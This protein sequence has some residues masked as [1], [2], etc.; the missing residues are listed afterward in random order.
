M[1]HGKSMKCEILQT[2]RWNILNERNWELST[3]KTSK[4]IHTRVFWRWWMGRCKICVNTR[5]FSTKWWK[6]L[7]FF[8]IFWYYEERRKINISKNSY[9]EAEHLR[10]RARPDTRSRRKDFFYVLRFLLKCQKKMSSGSQKKCQR[11]MV[12][13]SSRFFVFNWG[14][15]TIMTWCRFTNRYDDSVMGASAIDDDSHKQKK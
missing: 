4:K 7:F 14:K 6:Y 1:T 12:L 15:D 8:N 11:F 13:F 9:I 3:N 2:F 10:E 5:K